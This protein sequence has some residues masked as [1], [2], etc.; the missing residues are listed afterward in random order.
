MTTISTISE[1]EKAIENLAENELQEIRGWFIK[2][3]NAKW[4]KEIERDIKSGAL[5]DMAQDAINDYKS[6]NCREL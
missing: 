3:D 1:I 5:D 6:G 2:Y 4:D